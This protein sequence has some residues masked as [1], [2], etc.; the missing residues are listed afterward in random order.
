[1]IDLYTWS[2]PNGRKVS[3]ML[4]ELGLPY[5]VH[6]IDIGKGDQFKPDFV[7]V[8]PN[9]KIPAIVDSEGPEA[10]PYAA[11]RVRCDPAV[12]GGE[13]G[14][15]LS[16]RPN[17]ALR[18]NSVADVPDGRRRTDVRPDPSLSARRAGAGSLR[19]RT[20]Q[21]GNAQAIRRYWTSTWQAATGWQR[22]IP[23]PTS[24]P[25]R[26]SP[27]MTGTRSSWPIFR[28]SS[29]GTTRSERARPCSAA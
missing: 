29:A 18:C 1:M 7:A 13:D 22:I 5:T 26:G 27:A 15:F 24:P 12:S 21:Q 20:L 14:R 23:L 2:T 4:E 11:V 3:I 9:S 28:T 25:I 19:D 16:T 17:R 8:S 6:A 10:Q